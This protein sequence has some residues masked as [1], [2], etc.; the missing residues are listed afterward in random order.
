MDLLKWVVFGVLPAVAAVLLGVGAGGPRFL[1]ASLA[2]AVCVP[3]GMAVGWPDWPWLL[4][5]AHGDPFAWLWWVLFAAGL[6]GVAYDTKVLPKV[7]LIAAEVALVAFLPW[8]LSAPLRA[9]WNFEWC[10]VWLSAGWLVLGLTWW[11]LRRV[12][13]AQPGMVVPFVG[14]LA[15][16]ADA[17]VLRARGADLDWQLAGIAAVA[18]GMAV[19]TTI[20]RRPFVCGTGGTL[21]ITVTHVG[22]L[23]CGRPVGELLRSEVLLALAV[24][25]PLGVALHGVFKDGRT[26]GVVVGVIGCIGLAAAAIAAA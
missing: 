13:K 1:A 11:V 7:L 14:A 24:P 25:L 9:R 21:A 5:V 12:A 23:Y 3:F 10:V 18:L 17:V 4:S 26:T 6:I 16:V 2:V 15:C 19:A 22:L 8:L 20:W